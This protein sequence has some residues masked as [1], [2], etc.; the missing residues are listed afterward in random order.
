MDAKENPILPA[1]L[2]SLIYNLHVLNLARET[3]DGWIY[4]QVG[5]ENS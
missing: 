5:K 3:G 2:P 4:E 1:F